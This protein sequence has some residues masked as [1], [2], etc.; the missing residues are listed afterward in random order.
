MSLSPSKILP[1]SLLII[2]SLSKI[3]IAA[4]AADDKLTPYDAL[5]T[6]NFPQGLL[7]KGSLGYDLDD[8]TG[9][10]KAYFNGSCSFSL[11]GSY[12]LRYRPTISGIISKNK[13]TDLSGV[14]VKVMFV[15]LNIV[16]IKRK[17]DNL[18][19]SVGI[20]SADF[21][22]DNFDECPQ[23]GCGMNCNHIGDFVSS[24]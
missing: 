20:M 7:P 21:P 12:Q 2:L 5:Q 22:V 8:E 18:E 16:E 14:S 4:A 24:I 17:E 11:E 10:F 19:F 13:L 9:N 15:W 6:F 23:C 3:T 1:I